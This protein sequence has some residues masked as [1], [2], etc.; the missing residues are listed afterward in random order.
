ML[1]D[2]LGATPLSADCSYDSMKAVLFVEEPASNVAYL[3]NMADPERLPAPPPPLVLLFQTTRPFLDPI[4]RR[5]DSGFVYSVEENGGFRQLHLYNLDTREDMALTTDEYEH[6]SPT[7]PL[8]NEMVVYEKQLSEGAQLF[9]NFF[10]VGSDVQLTFGEPH[11]QP[12]AS[13]LQEVITCQHR[14]EGIPQVTVI[15][16]DFFD[17]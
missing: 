6:V 8:S 14:V 17:L 3:M 16:L 10:E 2:Q 7:I 9:A 1:Y 15:P 11:L 4:M 5:D 12:V 13:D